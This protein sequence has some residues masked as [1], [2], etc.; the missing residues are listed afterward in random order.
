MAIH[1]RET[2]VVDN[3]GSGMSGGIIA[4]VVLV[5]VVVLAVLFFNGTFSGGGSGT[6]DV[7]V[8]AVSIDVV[9]DGQ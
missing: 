7:D 2:V 4:G 8:P 9:P 5:L 1:E 6:I 3:G